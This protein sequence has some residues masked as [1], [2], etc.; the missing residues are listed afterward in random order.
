MILQEGQHL[1]NGKVYDYCLTA[2]DGQ[3]IYLNDRDLTKLMRED[4][5]EEIAAGRCDHCN[6][7]EG[8]EKVNPDDLEVNKGDVSGWINDYSED[9][10]YEVANILGISTNAI[11]EDIQITLV[12]F[13]VNN[14]CWLKKFNSVEVGHT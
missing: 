1:F 6:Y 11:I 8:C 4:R 3:I 13:F 14:V 12:K 7:C 10:A 2:D 9:M 5:M